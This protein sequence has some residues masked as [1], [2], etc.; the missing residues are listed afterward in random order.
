M[1]KSDNI[2]T[3]T[4]YRIE[5]HKRN[6]IW[7][8]DSNKD[9]V[10]IHKLKK[11]FDEILDENIIKYDNSKMLFPAPYYTDLEYIK[12]KYIARLSDDEK[13]GPPSRNVPVPLPFWMKD[14]QFDEEVLNNE[15]NCMEK[16]IE[17][18][19]TNYR[20]QDCEEKFKNFGL[21]FKHDACM[22]EN[23]IRNVKR[24]IGKTTRLGDLY[25]HDRLI[26]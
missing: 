21:P 14:Q 16:I 18:E 9:G 6:A 17:K 26:I 1:R 19:Q 10:Y 15:D 7:V 20:I 11:V 8:S 25:F 5:S 13:K 3:E 2:F 4:Y 24:K 12:S 22:Y 23:K